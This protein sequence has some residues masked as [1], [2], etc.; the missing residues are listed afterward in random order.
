VRAGSGEA[1]GVGFDH[2]TKVI[3]APTASLLQV[4]ADVGE[5]VFR[6][7]LV[8]QLAVGSGA[9]GGRR[10]EG[11]PGGVRT[12]VGLRTSPEMGRKRKGSGSFIENV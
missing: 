5:V 12:E 4:T 11:E 2:G 8:Q 10:A 7:G 3:A 1:T 9:V 6:S